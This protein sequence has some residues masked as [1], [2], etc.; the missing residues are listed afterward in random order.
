MS[1]FAS[2][3]I[4]AYNRPDLLRRSLESL[5]DNTSYPYELI[6]HDDGSRGVT[7]S[8]LRSMLWAGKISTLIMNP[9]DHNRGL[10]V[11]VN[12]AVDISE[13]KYIIKVNGDDRFEPGWL[14][15]AVE[16]MQIYPEIGLL[17][18]ASYNYSGIHNKRFPDDY[19]EP[20]ED[21]T[22][23]YREIRDGLPVRVVWC[24]P[25]DGLM[26]T[27]KTWK[28][29]GPWRSNYDPSFGA[30][31]HWRMDCCPMMRRPLLRPP[32]PAAAVEPHQLR[33]H[34]EKYRKTP[35][36]AMMDPPVLDFSWGNGLT[37]I[38]EAQKTLKHGPLLLGGK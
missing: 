12:R 27:R 25:G 20:G 19:W 22:T 29:V 15:K 23:L 11:S 21:R 34:W 30:D 24:G 18:L 32:D 31:V 17:H 2:I 3:V 14:T 13:G 26:F 1:D 6:V 37:I 33:G 7:I 4:S 38:S 5:W 28:R 35:W 8:Y 16:V 9:L 10:G 36:L